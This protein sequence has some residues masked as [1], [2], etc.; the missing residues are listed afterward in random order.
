ML[1]KKVGIALAELIDFLVSI[2]GSKLFDLLIFGHSLGAHICGV[3]GKNVKSMQIP[4]IVGLD[5]AYPMVNIFDIDSRLS[6]DDAEHVQVIHTN[7]GHLGLP[8]PLGHADFYPNWGRIQPGCSGIEIGN[9]C[10]AKYFSS[11][12]ISRNHYAVLLC[13]NRW[14]FAYSFV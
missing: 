10:I 9:L 13:L 7:A 8:Y 6:I 4:V 11:E 1:R 3:A 14:L 2:H 12:L 5:P